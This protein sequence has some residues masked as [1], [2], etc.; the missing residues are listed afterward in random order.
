MNSSTSPAASAAATV[1]SRL[2][3][4][5]TRASGHD[6]SAGSA[7]SLAIRAAPRMPQ[8]TCLATAARFGRAA[9]N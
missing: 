4:A 1:A 2:A 6:D 5:W 7:R 8:P 9:G 3:I